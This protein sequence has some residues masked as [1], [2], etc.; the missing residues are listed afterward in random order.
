MSELLDSK[1]KRKELLRGIIKDLHTGADVDAVKSQFAKLLQNVSPSEIA[2]IESQLIAEGLPEQEVKRLCDVH[3]AVFEESLS[4]QQPPEL[5][6][7]HPVHTMRLENEAI[8]KVI[9]ALRELLQEVSEEANESRQR[10]YCPAIGDKVTALGEIHKHYLRKENHLF[11]FLERHGVEGPPKVMWALHD[12]IRAAIKKLSR[13]VAACDL[14]S[15]LTDGP[16]VLDMVGDMIYKE[17]NIL[18]PMALDT[19]SEL[20]WGQVKSGEEEIGYTLVKPGDQ[21]QARERM[22][23]GQ[24]GGAPTKPA[25]TR[26]LRLDMG[27]LTADEV[28]LVLTHLPVDVTYVNAENEVRYYSQGAERIFPRSPAI[29]GRK[30]QNCHPPDSVGVVEK[31]VNEFEKG[32]KNKAEFWLEMDGRFILIRYFAVRDNDGRYRGVIEVSQDVTEIRQLEGE[33]RLLDW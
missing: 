10:D 21:W 4:D 7:G 23:G 31:I 6:P 12:D 27:R 3:V 26:A 28:N 8:T 5:V 20:E 19:L 30:V 1:E 25:D 9:T 11:P 15:I 14:E 18:F 24:Q 13:A 32:T 2:A 17:E 33:R 29:I 22:A 16:P